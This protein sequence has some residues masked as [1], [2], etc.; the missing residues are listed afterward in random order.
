MAYEQLKQMAQTSFEDFYRFCSGDSDRKSHCQ[1]GIQN[2]NGK[3][4]GLGG[5]LYG[6]EN[7]DVCDGSKCPV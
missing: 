3:D 5:Y 1:A 7:Y 2:D 6:I 4:A